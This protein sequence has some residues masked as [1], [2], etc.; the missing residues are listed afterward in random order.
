MFWNAVGKPGKLQKELQ[1][2]L[3]HIGC[4]DSFLRTVNPHAA[5]QIAE[6]SHRPR[7][8]R[9][10]AG[11]V[12]TKKRALQQHEPSFFWDSLSWLFHI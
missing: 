4:A 8:Y 2:N 7:V 9:H 10:T 1:K 5:Q 11:F 12:R 6:C 3:A